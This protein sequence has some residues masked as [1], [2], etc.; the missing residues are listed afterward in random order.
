VTERLSHALNDHELEAVLAH[1]LTHIADRDA[2]V[3][4][5]VSFPRTLGQTLIGDDSLA[6]A[7][8]SSPARRST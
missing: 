1:K 7:Q 5:V 6:A 2:A 3:M 8:R 4:T